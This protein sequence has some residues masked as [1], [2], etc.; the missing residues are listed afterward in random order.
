MCLVWGFG[1]MGLGVN[2]P[3]PMFGM[4]EVGIGFQTRPG[5]GPG[6]ETLIYGFHETH[7]G[8]VSYGSLGFN[9]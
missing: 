9:I 4:S 2:P 1:I 8:W 3:K 7:G 5:L 6:H